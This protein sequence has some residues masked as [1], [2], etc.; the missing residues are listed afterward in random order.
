MLGFNISFICVLV[1]WA[2]ITDDAPPVQRI[3]KEE[4]S[5]YS[6][7]NSRGQVFDVEKGM[8]H[9]GPNFGRLVNSFYA[10]SLAFVTG[11]FTDTSLTD[12]VSSLTSTQVSSLCDMLQADWWGQF[13]SDGGEPTEAL[14]QVEAA[15]K[16]QAQ[17]EENFVHV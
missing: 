12:D 13:Y 5:L 7:E 10:A 17:A 14:L 16:D 4:L 6:G 8:K 3:T 11:D 2:H 9:Y 15:L 1:D